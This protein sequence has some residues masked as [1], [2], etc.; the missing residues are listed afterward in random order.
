M[1]IRWKIQFMSQKIWICSLRKVRICE[2][3][4]YDW[5]I[6]EKIPAFKTEGLKTDKLKTITV[7][8]KDLDL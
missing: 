5:R 2:K 8:I 3:R 7:E 6:G 4:G 1:I